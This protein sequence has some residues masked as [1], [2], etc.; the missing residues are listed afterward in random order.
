MNAR[1][2]YLE[3]VGKEYNRAKEGGRGRLLDEAEKRAGLN[4]KYLIRMRDL[5]SHDELVAGRLCCGGHNS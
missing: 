5:R 1:K 3:E 4:R 2:Q